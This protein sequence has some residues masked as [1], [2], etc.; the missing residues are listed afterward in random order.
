M[1]SRMTKLLPLILAFLMILQ[2][3]PVSAVAGELTEETS[4]ETSIDIPIDIPEMEKPD[5]KA[6]TV[7][8]L[9]SNNVIA[10]EEAEP[11]T[12]TDPGQTDQETIIPDEEGIAEDP[13]PL[14]PENL[15]PADT[16]AESSEP[17]TDDAGIDA[18]EIPVESEEPEPSEENEQE[19]LPSEDP[20]SEELPDAVAVDDDPDE[21]DY[22]AIEAEYDM[23][24]DD[25]Y[26]SWPDVTPE[27]EVD[28]VYD[29][30]WI[31]YAIYNEDHAY[32][33]IKRATEIYS[34]SDLANEDMLFLLDDRNV[35]LLA[36]EHCQRRNTVSVHVWFMTPD[37]VITDGYIFEKDLIN[38]TYPDEEALSLA[39]TA[40]HSDM[41]VGSLTLPVFLAEV[42][43]PENDDESIPV[44]DPEDQSKDDPEGTPEDEPSEINEPEP[45]PENNESEMTTEA[46]PEEETDENDAPVL[47]GTVL[48]MSRSASGLSNGQEVTVYRGDDLQRYVRSSDGSA[49][50]ATYRHYVTLTVNGTQKNFDALCLN[51]KRSSST[52]GFTGTLIKGKDYNPN[53]TTMTDAQKAKADGMFWILLETNYSD[54]FDTAIAQWAVWKYGGGDDYDSNVSKV[55]NLAAGRGF[56]YD[57][58][59]MR[60][61]MNALIDGARDF[62]ANGGVPTTSI[63]ASASDVSRTAAGHSQVTVSLN[64]NGTQCRIAKS[65]LPQSTVTGYQNEDN[66]YY[67][68]N[69][70]ASFTIDFTADQLNF[71][72]DA[73]TRY[74]Q[75]EYWVG[76]VSSGNRQDMGFIVYTGNIGATANLSVKAL[77]PYG[78]IRVLKLD[79]SSG[80]ALPGV[81]FEL[82]NAAFQQVA[83]GTTDQSGILLFSHLEPGIYYVHETAAPAGYRADD[84]LYS[85]E[86]I[87]NDQTVEI[88]VNN[89]PIQFRV[90]IIKT[91]SLTNRP[92]PGA[93]FTVVRKSGL[94]GDSID[95]IVAVLVTGDDG[96]AV[97]DLLSWGEYEITETT[98]PDGYLD[99]GYTATAR[100]N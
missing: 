10:S 35:L 22:E 36:L 65:Q 61:M 15:G 42:K 57:T 72:V 33:R 52:S 79:A 29:G 55:S 31:K 25:N 64:S 60:A 100:M 75:Y 14:E 81:S 49:T 69:P 89:Q 13:M 21:I 96:K 85:A 32:V 43:L 19:P 53:G 11:E 73:W 4:V 47:R 50:T 71:D 20:P 44:D 2:V 70:N 26:E 87:E 46:D 80:N 30:S 34:D 86:V 67:Y 99:E 41:K 38:E 37:M 48:K 24:F 83:T 91:D 1:K 7:P 23:E 63:T 56:Q 3:L 5:E 98:V 97:S 95:V 27:E 59:T 92:L 54:P 84:A 62:V 76:D 77:K 18:E 94:P 90:E 17:L 58:A 16:E 28:L 8:D 78:N 68:F 39:Q 93:V 88:T 45:S 40:V 9:V 74:D 6:E 51:A 12:E 66:S 82:L